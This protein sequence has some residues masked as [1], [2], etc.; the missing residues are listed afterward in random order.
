MDFKNTSD[1]DRR[2]RPG[3]TYG[4]I[5]NKI[6]KMTRNATC[7]TEL[8]ANNGKEQR[9]FVTNL[10]FEIQADLFIP[11]LRYHDNT[12]YKQGFNSILLKS[13]VFYTDRH[14]LLAYK[15]IKVVIT[16]S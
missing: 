3:Q 12:A 14:T 13:S 6:V 2:G 8:L 11:H 4:D 7:Q 16:P 9:K 10:K 1:K 15:T 5:N